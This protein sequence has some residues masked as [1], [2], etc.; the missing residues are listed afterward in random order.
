MPSR[1][2]T[3]S[4]PPPQRPP[5]CSAAAEPAVQLIGDGLS[6][7]ACR[8]I[9]AACFFVSVEPRARLAW[10]CLTLSVVII[11]LNEEANLARTLASVAWVDEIV[12]VDSGSTDRTRE[13]AESFHPTFFVT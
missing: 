6:F 11:T 2:N 13:V 10:D 1:R 12:V 5:A 4:G 8:L 9:R 7:Q 3:A